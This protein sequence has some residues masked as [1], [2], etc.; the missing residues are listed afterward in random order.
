MITIFLPDYCGTAYL[1]LN[2]ALAALFY[3]N[4]KLSPD[5]REQM[6]SQKFIGEPF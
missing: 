5:I 4:L 1:L 2:L 3:F 6:N